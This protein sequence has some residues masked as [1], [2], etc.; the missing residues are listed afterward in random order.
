MWCLKVSF[1]LSMEDLL[2]LRP[3][4]VSK[5]RGLRGLDVPREGKGRAEAL[6]RA[7]AENER[8]RGHRA[9]LLHATRVVHGLPLRDFEDLWAKQAEAPI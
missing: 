1:T 9:H 2:S 7:R 3:S 8:G 4:I 5:W 6:S